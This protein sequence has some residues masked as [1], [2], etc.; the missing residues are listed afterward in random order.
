MTHDFD[1]DM[2]YEVADIKAEQDKVRLEMEQDEEPEVTGLVRIPYNFAVRTEQDAALVVGAIQLRRSTAE[3]IR[4]QAEAMAT[5]AERS[6][7]WLE[8][9]FSYQLE[10]YAKEHISGK[11]RSITLLTGQSDK[12]ARIGFRKQSS[13]LQITDHEK[14]V[15]WAKENNLNDCVKTTVIEK[16]VAAGFIQH[17]QNTGEVPPGCQITEEQEKF[18]IS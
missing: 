12:P 14:A 16:T 2:V 18:Y 7:E 10:Q 11:T 9:Q 13:R 5:Q 8:R 4:A 15:A 1:E 6:A 3:R 17:F